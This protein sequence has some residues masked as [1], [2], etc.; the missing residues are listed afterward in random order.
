VPV[1]LLLQGSD[2]PWASFWVITFALAIVSFYTS[3]AA[4]VKA[5]L[6]PAEVRAIG[7]GLSY[8]VANA[9]F[10]GTAELIALSFKAGGYEN[11]YY[12]Y[13]TVMLAFAFFTSLSLPR[14]PHYL[15][16]DE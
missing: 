11:G 4:I 2:N 3:V 16:K 10:G 6:F 13:V 8:A 14:K 12:Y 1:I 7:V 15:L 9:I 5:E